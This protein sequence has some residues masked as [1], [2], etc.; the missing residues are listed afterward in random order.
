M[1]VACTGSFRNLWLWT[2]RNGDV[3]DGK[4]RRICRL[5]GDGVNADRRAR[6][7]ELDIL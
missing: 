6:Q 3:C 2:S 1:L 7:A 4:A 5:R